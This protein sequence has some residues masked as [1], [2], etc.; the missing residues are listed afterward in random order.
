MSWGIFCDRMGG[1]IWTFISGVGMAITLAGIAWVL[2]N[3]TGMADFKIFLGLMLA[4]FLFSGFGNAG[5]FKQIADDYAGPPGWRCHRLHL[6]HRTPLGPFL[7]R[8]RSLRPVGTGGAWGL[9]SWAGAIFCA[10]CSVLCWIMYAR[11]NA[12]FPG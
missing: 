3:P 5:T 12:P 2:H 6:R 8:R 10:L 1:A 9:P 4:M 7:R 11:K